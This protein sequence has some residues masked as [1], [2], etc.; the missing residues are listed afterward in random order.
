M[1]KLTKMPREQRQ[2]IVLTN[3]LRCMAFKATQ[4]QRVASAVEKLRAR[5]GA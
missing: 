4:P 2:A 1:T 3:V 5:W